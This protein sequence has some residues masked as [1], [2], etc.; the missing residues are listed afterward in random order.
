MPTIPSGTKFMGVN[1]DVNTDERRSSL[2][3]SYQE[4]YTIDEIVA[5]ASAA[6]TNIYNSDGTLDA[7]RTVD[8]DGNT[9]NFNDGKV[10]VNVTPG[11]PLQVRRTAVPSAG[12]TI[13]R[14]DVSDSLAYL[15][16]V[17]GTSA[18]GVFA[19]M[20]QGKQIGTSAQ[21]ALI[22]EG[23][24]D[25]ADDTGT[26][27]VTLFKTRL[28][29][30]LQVVTRP[31]FQFSNWTLDIMTMLADGKVGIGTTVPTAPLHVQTTAIPSVNENIARFTV[32]DAA[33]AEMKIINASSVNGRF[34]PE[35]YSKQGANTDT[36]FKQTSY[37]DP[38]QDS[39][40]TPVTVFAAALGT[41]ATAIVTRPLYQ[42][43]NAANSLLTI[44]ANGNVGIGTTTPT[45]KLEVDGKTKTTTFQM[46][47]TPTAGYVLTSD[48]SGN[49]TWTAASGGLTN[50]TEAENTA[51]PNATVPVNSLTATGAAT[52]IDVAIVPKGNGAFT[53]D[54]ADN[55]T[56]GGN[57]RGTRAVDLQMERSN[58][59]QVASGQWSFVAG[60]NNRASTD[61]ANA[62]GVENIATG[63]LGSFACGYLSSA[64][65]S[66]SKA[67]G[68]L[69]T[70]SGSNGSVAIGYTNTASGTSSVALGISNQ[71]TGAASVA[72][73]SNAIANADY[74]FASGFYTRVLE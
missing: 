45:E 60:K 6:D 64:I 42:F 66:F 28:T 40:T 19:P 54:I 5:E 32:S 74:S 39:G 25:V 65:G 35:L 36:V 52:D 1:P 17:N 26:A 55:T 31:V 12:E 8:L 27:P 38:T 58:A 37:I 9:I 73:T 15:S 4:F 57:K 7:N 50:F 51:A 48:A 67:H 49:G 13:A 23:I 68:Y 70:A 47:T 46:T 59:N 71:A 16:V 56:A 30:L 21:S 69:N 29:G 24:I 3:N 41:I 20:I 72:L 61:Y 33:G 2:S 34:V 44:L 53:L 22:T 18:N 62:L 11:F 10:G 14:F 63:S 43:R